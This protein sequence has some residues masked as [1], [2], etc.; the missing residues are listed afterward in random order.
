MSASLEQIPSI[1][2]TPRLRLR[3]LH[4]GDGLALHAALDRT[5]D[6]LEGIEL[7]DSVAEAVELAQRY[8]A[9]FAAGLR[10]VFG[11]FDR[12]ETKLFGC[13]QVIPSPLG[14][15]AVEFGYWLDKMGRGQGYAAESVGALTGVVFD[16]LRVDQIEILCDAQNLKSVQVASRLGYELAATLP[17]WRKI[18]AI[19]HDLQIWRIDRAGY[20]AS[21]AALIPI[22]AEAELPTAASDTEVLWDSLSSPIAALHPASRPAE[23]TLL[24]ETQVAVEGKQYPQSVLMEL[25]SDNQGMPWLMLAALIGPASLFKP[26]D[27]LEHNSTLVVGAVALEEDML[28]LRQVFDAR[29]VSLTCLNHSLMVLA[30]EATLLREEFLPTLDAA[31]RVFDAYSD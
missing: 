5:K 6:E 18:G 19:R 26:K 4:A 16:M 8:R 11:I 9:D 27:A 21:A 2:T 24:L 22:T 23:Y 14:G 15:N 30:H 17:R 7:A 28:V 1:L 3:C 10:C 13:V 12:S 20:P 31:C 29:A 25:G